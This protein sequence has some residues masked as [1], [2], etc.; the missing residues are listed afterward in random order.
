[1]K[2]NVIG[3]LW[4]IGMIGIAAAGGAFTADAGVVARP[5]ARQVDT[6]S[7]TVRYA[8]LDLS[9]QAGVESLYQRLR[10]AARHVCGSK[11]TRYLEAVRDWR[12][13]HNTALEQ[14]IKEVANERLT[15]VHEDRAGHP[16]RVVVPMAGLP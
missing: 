10:T 8:D 4:M 6:R 7:V 1:M 14:A 3:K 12:R 9:E 2:R 5:A 16:G 13:C 15:A 11:E